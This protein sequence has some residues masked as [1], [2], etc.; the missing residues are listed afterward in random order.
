MD[1]FYF[2][3]G[4]QILSVFLRGGGEDPFDKLV[5]YIFSLF[6]DFQLGEVFISESK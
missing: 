6:E 1:P 2:F 3:M 4:V 5:T